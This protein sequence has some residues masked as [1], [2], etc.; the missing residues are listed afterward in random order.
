MTVLIHLKVFVPFLDLV[1]AFGQK[2]HVDQ[3]ACDGGMYS[4]VSKS[5]GNEYCSGWG[6]YIRYLAKHQSEMKKSQKLY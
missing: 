1:H 4:H 2:T 3:K 5:G 6:T